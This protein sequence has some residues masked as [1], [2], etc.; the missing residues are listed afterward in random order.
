MRALALCI[1]EEL[2]FLNGSMKELKEV[3][4]INNFQ[5]SIFC[6]TFC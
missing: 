2:N 3:I 5:F 4:S 1:Y 6:F